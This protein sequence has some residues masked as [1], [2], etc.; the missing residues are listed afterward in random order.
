MTLLSHPWTSNQ[1]Q[2]HT[3]SH[4]LVR[5]YTDRSPFA[6]QS[7]KRMTASHKGTCSC[8]SPMQRVPTCSSLSYQCATAFDWRNTTFSPHVHDAIE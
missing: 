8:T 6:Q 2:H 7:N 5:L 1:S 4:L 3:T